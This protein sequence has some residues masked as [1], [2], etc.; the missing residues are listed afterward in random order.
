MSWTGLKFKSRAIGHAEPTPPSRPVRRLKMESMEA[1][2]MMAADG[3]VDP[4]PS[5]SSE[6]PTDAPPIFGD[7]GTL[8][9]VEGRPFR[10]VVRGRDPDG[11]DRDLRY[12]VGENAPE[13]LTVANR[14]AV[15]WTPGESDGGQTHE[16]E[17]IATDGVNETVG[18]LKIDVRE[19]NFKPRL[20]RIVTPASVMQGGELAFDVSATDRD[21]PAPTLTYT[22]A[23]TVPEGLTIDS[24]G[25]MRWSPDGGT[26]P[27]RYR[28]GVSVS[29][30]EK[31]DRRNYLIDVGEL[32]TPPTLVAADR[33]D[34]DSGVN[35]TVETEASD[36]Q[37]PAGRLQ[38]SLHGDVPRGMRIDQTGRI[39]WTPTHDQAGVH[40]VRVRAT[41]DSRVR[42]HDE[43][44][45][46]FD[47]R[48][49]RTPETGAAEAFVVPSR[50]RIDNLEAFAVLFALAVEG[51]DLTDDSQVYV[52]VP[53]QRSYVRADREIEVVDHDDDPDTPGIKRHLFTRLVVGRTEWSTR[54]GTDGLWSVVVDRDGDYDPRRRRIDA[55]DA[56]FW[57]EYDANDAPVE[58]ASSLTIGNSTS[59]V[60]GT[61]FRPWH[62]PDDPQTIGILGID[63][64]EGETIR[65]QVI[66]RDATVTTL[67]DLPSGASLDAMLYRVTPHQD[68]VEHFRIDSRWGGLK[69]GEVHA[70]TDQPTTDSAAVDAVLRDAMPW[71][72]V[73]SFGLAATRKG[74]RSNEAP[75][76]FVIEDEVTT[77][78]AGQEVT[79]DLGWQPINHSNVTLVPTADSPAGLT[80][81]RTWRYQ[82]NRRGYQYSLRWRD[83]PQ[84]P[85]SRQFQVVLRRPGLEQTLDVAVRRSAPPVISAPRLVERDGRDRLT[86]PVSVTDTD[87]QT[88]SHRLSTFGSLGSRVA[89]NA[90]RDG[91]VVD[92]SDVDVPNQASHQRVVMVVGDA[93][94]SV[95]RELWI[96]I[97]R[98]F[99]PPPGGLAFRPD[100]STRWDLGYLPDAVGSPRLITDDDT[101]ANLTFHET[102]E[103]DAPFG[104]SRYHLTWT[105]DAEAPATASFDV[106]LDVDGVRRT[107]PVEAVRNA[108]PTS[109]VRLI[110]RPA[111]D[112][113]DVNLSATD[114]ESDRLAFRVIDD[115]GVSVAV[116][117]E[118]V[119]AFDVSG[120]ERS[121]EADFRNVRIGID[122]G[123]GEIFQDIAVNVGRP[124]GPKTSKIVHRGTSAYHYHSLGWLPQSVGTLRLSVGD[125]GPN[126]VSLDRTTGYRDGQYVHVYRLR[127][128]P[129]PGDEANI[130]FEATLTG[131]GFTRTFSLEAVYNG[132]PIVEL[133]DPIERRDRETIEVQLRASDPEG[134]PLRFTLPNYPPSYAT[135][136]ETGLLTLDFTG[137][138][139]AVSTNWRTL[140]YYV[141]DGHGRRS[142][143]IEINTGRA[144]SPLYADDGF[145]DSLDPTTIDAGS[146]VVAGSPVGIDRRDGVWV[147]DNDV[148]R[149]I[150]F[151][152]DGTVS[153]AIALSAAVTSHVHDASNDAIYLGYYGGQIGKIDLSATVPTQ[154]PFADVDGKVS[155]IVATPSGFVAYNGSGFKFVSL[156][157]QGQ[158]I[159]TFYRS[160]VADLS[161]DAINDQIIYTGWYSPR[162]LTARSLSGTDGDGN[163]RAGIFGDGRT[164][165]EYA[166]P[167]RAVGVAGVDPNGRY[168][169]TKTGALFDAQTV[170]FVADI[171]FL[172]A[173]G[174]ATDASRRYEQIIWRTDGLYTVRGDGDGSLIQRWRINDA[175][176]EAVSVDWLQSQPIAGSVTALFGTTDDADKLLAFAIVAEGPPRFTEV[177]LGSSD[178]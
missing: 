119:L 6:G 138:G 18:V 26:P 75:R 152:S 20:P 139:D 32:N 25:V 101:P 160:G 89:W 15:R 124:F 112:R 29:D 8:R 174:E 49:S 113:F 111:S 16:V 66:P 41:D 86:I 120:I 96:N 173:D 163:S 110:E 148:N 108:A 80:L 95:E 91:L 63:D 56:V 39:R 105:D 145:N 118:G 42:M 46:T 4:L 68:V 157:R 76:P 116:D 169:V 133:M 70:T 7:L 159:D 82:N 30:G 109:P 147:H 5:L 31:S 98:P 54:R 2:R 128:Y 146:V 84:T 74:F 167:I 102:F 71:T 140:S 40:T 38:Y 107:F 57:F 78:R 61:Y 35:L 27:G 37:T 132:S 13:G 3:E 53:G 87:D 153:H 176:P 79:V 149:L 47:I 129:R 154:E 17:I 142:A 115:D 158:I 94:G 141:D 69:F 58:R 137:L 134:D 36:D 99:G 9:R 85:D 131:N 171:P 162:S 168:I 97:G 135:L 122:D 144:A 150:R 121:D 93:T 81:D 143:I 88:L 77:Y 55:T 151:E 177:T 175:D 92:L 43:A 48:D 125:D 114:D 52:R 34:G 44:E 103:R 1:R 104:Y 164:Y 67:N 59:V 127:W 100:T 24:D 33:I 126:N 28:I 65:E 156:D 23:G 11:P 12:R 45:I 161:Y 10:H 19:L 117:R 106:V 155:M 136:S 123:Y 72:P 60:G 130:P 21:L 64:R 90:E 62:R 14:G 50:V 166:G 51:N 83:D 73:R 178:A 165:R 172:D 22:L 170:N